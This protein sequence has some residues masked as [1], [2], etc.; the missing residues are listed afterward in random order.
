MRGDRPESED[1]VQPLGATARKGVAEFLCRLLAVPVPGLSRRVRPLPG[2]AGLRH[3]K[4]NDRRRSGFRRR[5]AGGA[6]GDS[7]GTRTSDD[8][9]D[10]KAIRVFRFGKTEWLSGGDQ[11]LNASGV[12]SGSG[13]GA[14]VRER[15]RHPLRVCRERSGFRRARMPGTIAMERACQKGAG[16]MERKGAG[17]DRLCDQWPAAAPP[18]GPRCGAPEVLRSLVTA[19]QDLQRLGRPYAACSPWGRRHARGLLNASRATRFPC[20]SFRALARGL[21]RIRPGAPLR[22]LRFAWGPTPAGTD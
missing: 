22:G 17:R 10:Q 16:A 11:G 1:R 15:D 4:P 6:D 9:A 21:N 5:R 12:R 2:F 19:H 8:D 13:S 7:G 20:S 14:L 3:R 18:W